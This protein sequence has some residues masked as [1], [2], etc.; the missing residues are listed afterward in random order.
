MTGQIF[1]S[2]CHNDGDF[3]ENLASKLKDNG[4][5][6][7]MDETGLE[8]GDEW[9]E[10]IDRSIRK[11]SALVLVVTPESKDSFYVTYEWIFALGAGL[12]VVPLK[13]KETEPHPRLRDIHHHDF[14]NRR[15]RPWDKLIADLKAICEKEP[16]E[17]CDNDVGIKQ[18]CSIEMP[19]NCPPIVENA[20]MSLDS[21]NAEERKNAIK[22]LAQC[23]FPSREK[24]LFSAMRR[25]PLEDVRSGIASV[26]GEIRTE[27]AVPELMEALKDTSDLV[28]SNAAHALTEIGDD[29]AISKLIEALGDANAS[30][31]ECAAWALGEIGDSVAVPRLIEALGD[32]NESVR[33]NAE[34][35]LAKIGG[36][37]AISKLIEALGDANA[38]VREYAASALG[39]IGD[40]TAI[41]RLTEATRDTDQ[42][43]RIEAAKALTRIRQNI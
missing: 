9:R 16:K 42:Y 23:N 10:E 32:T 24:V 1:I 4:L 13:L 37:T 39:E 43:V 31:R 21:V 18:A 38:S 25:H 40:S 29:T 35:A 41:L 17:K 34:H 20:I 12:K 14:T 3:A 6:F 26:L 7:W 5:K 36:D 28:R 8:G 30:V 22:L 2:Y 11:S 33:E 15:A 27:G 19:T